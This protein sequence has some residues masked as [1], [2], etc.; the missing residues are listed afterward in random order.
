VVASHDLVFH[1]DL[2]EKKR[3]RFFVTFEGER[4]RATEE[5]E[6]ADTE[7]DG[8]LRMRDE[9]GTAGLTKSIVA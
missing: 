5:V 7:I 9:V 3:W 2:A 8:P 1:E 6:D 4:P